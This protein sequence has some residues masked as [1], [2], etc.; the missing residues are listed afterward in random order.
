MRNNKIALSKW[1][2]LL[3]RASRGVEKFTRNLKF[4]WCTMAEARSAVSTPHIPKLEEGRDH[5]KDFVIAWRKAL[6]RRYFRTR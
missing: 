6:F 1:K 2:H 3:S 4:E 5:K